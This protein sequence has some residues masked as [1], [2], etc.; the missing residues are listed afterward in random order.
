MKKPIL[1]TPQE[2]AG[3][4]KGYTYGYRE[5]MKKVSMLINLILNSTD[6]FEQ[7]ILQNSEEAKELM[8]LFTE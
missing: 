3:F 5:G 8:E 6:E 2:R 7:I 4:E 1:T